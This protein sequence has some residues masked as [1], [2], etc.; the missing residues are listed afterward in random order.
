MPQHRNSIYDIPAGT[1][2]ISLLEISKIRPNPYQPRKFILP[3]Y[4]EQLAQNI[5]QHGQLDPIA[6]LPNTEPGDEFV[7]ID[8]QCRIEASKLLGKARVLACI[9]EKGD[10]HQLA[11]IMN[12]LRADPHPIDHAASLALL[13][14]R[15]GYTQ[16]KLAEVLN[17]DRTSVTELLLLNDLPDY[18]KEESPNHEKIGKTHLIE[19]ARLT[20]RPDTLREVFERMREGEPV[21]VRDLKSI[22]RGDSSKPSAS[23]ASTGG[24]R[25][26]VPRALRSVHRVITGAEQARDILKKTAPS[27]MKQNPD[28]LDLLREL[29]REIAAELDKLAGLDQPVLRILDIA[30]QVHEDLKSLDPSLMKDDPERLEEIK[31]LHAEIGASLKKFTPKRA[32]KTAS[33]STESSAAVDAGSPV[34]AGPEE[35]TDR[36]ADEGTIKNQSAEIAEVDLD[37]SRHD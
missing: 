34:L 31:R 12:R 28:K 36:G 16:E 37:T 11:L 13:M 30:K 10:P 2:E 29:H 26:T 22:R 35:T 20:D 19:L 4:I 7:L 3:G 32:R 14:E 5:K 27:L 8:G 24:E 33:A 21:G 15:F 6:V 9:H 17:E 23:N 1:P 25:Q 18:I